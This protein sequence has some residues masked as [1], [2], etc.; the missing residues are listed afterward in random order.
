M[1]LYRLQFGEES[2]RPEELQ[3]GLAR[4]LAHAPLRMILAQIG[5]R[6]Q[7][8]LALEGC[9]GCAYLRC[10]PGCYADLLRRMLQLTCG[11]SLH[12]SQGLAP[13]GFTHMV[14]AS[15]TR[16][17]HADVHALLDAYSD[18]RIILDWTWHGKAAQL[19]VLLLTCDD[20]PNPASHVRACGWRSWPVPRL[21]VGIALRQASMLHVQLPLSSRWPHAPVLLRA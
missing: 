4:H 11:A 18:A 9:A 7:A 19:G 12:A 5:Q 2:R 1:Q 20:G 3:A 21:A 15:P 13:R 6:R 8:Y 17:V 10:E 16:R 14:L